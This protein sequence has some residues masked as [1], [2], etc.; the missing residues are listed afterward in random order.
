MFTHQAASATIAIPVGRS[1]TT[2]HV[3][4]ADLQQ[5]VRYMVESRKAYDSATQYSVYC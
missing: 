3:L 2:T 1:P 4:T 5:R